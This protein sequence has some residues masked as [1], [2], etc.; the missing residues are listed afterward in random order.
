[1]P[2]W[3]DQLSKAADEDD[4]D[5]DDGDYVPP[6]AAL[7]A[8]EAELAAQEASGPIPARR[9]R[10]DEGQEGAALALFCEGCGRAQ[11]A[12]RRVST[13]PSCGR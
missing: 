3:F 13:P 2:T 5:E 7:E 10:G 4:S 11:E 1:M 9:D 12:A 8:L 6:P